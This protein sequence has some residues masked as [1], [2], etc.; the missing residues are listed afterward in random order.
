MQSFHNKKTPAKPSGLHFAR[1]ILVLT[2]I[3]LVV[4]LIAVFEA[5]ATEA[6]NISGDNFFLVKRQALWAIVAVIGL[7]VSSFFPIKIIKTFAPFMYILGVV[8]LIAIFIPAVGVTEKG[9][10]RW[11]AIAGFQFQ[12]VE[13][14]KLGIVTYFPTWLIKHQR[15]TPFLMLTLIPTVLVLLQPD[16]G[17][18]LIVLAICFGLYIGANA[19]LSKILPIA[20]VGVFC[21]SLIIMFSPY[22]RERLMTFFDPQKDP[23]DTG[24]HMRQI[25]IALGNGGIFGKGLGQ[26]RQRHYIPET[27][28]DSIFAIVAEETGLFG[29][30]LLIFLLMS[31]VTQ[32]FKLTTS[33]EPQSYE[34][35]LALG[36]TIWIS[37]QII[38]N[39]AAV[40]AL[41]PLT[42]IPL[43]LI[44][45]GGTALVTIMSIIGIL[46][47][48]ERNHRVMK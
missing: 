46:V 44:S 12:P 4:G 47:S 16:L 13:I 32:S 14:M 17:S 1:S 39:L 18:T 7:A 24:F 20:F 25:T 42:G 48:L 23:Y 34:Y 37:S 9:A 45:R 43:P 21:L 35:L 38:L 27:S 15:L 6:Y 11:L 30:A 8:M 33:L 22:R 40:V 2:I 19:D 5:S 36:I 31:L 29:G 26:S 41:V 28:T 10:T 3:L